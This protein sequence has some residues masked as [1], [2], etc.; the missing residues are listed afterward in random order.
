MLP[1]LA[2]LALAA[3]ALAG[4]AAL[5]AQGETPLAPFAAQRVSV[6]PVQFLRAD[7]AG[8]VRVATWAA[9]RRELDDS[10]GVTLAERGLGRNW[11]YATDIERMAKR[12]TAYVS[13]PFT[14]GAGSLRARP[15]RPEDQA[16]MILVNNLRS[17][18]ALGDSRYAIIP[19]ELSFA[20][21][22]AD[23][24]AVLR[25]VMLDG[26]SGKIVWFADVT[27]PAGNAFGSGEIGA[28]SRRVADLVSR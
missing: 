8:P 4:P 11:A 9:V 7:S 19:V 6:M 26:R 12:N 3:L 13:D 27:S 15:L 22:G 17:L 16:P 28:L 1:P 14:L 5:R 24:S 20:R 21:R 18:I 25:L 10:I 23:S 2:A